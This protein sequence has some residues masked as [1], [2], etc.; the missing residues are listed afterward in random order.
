MRTARKHRAENNTSRISPN[1]RILAIASGKGGVGKSSVSAR[2]A[3]TLAQGGRKV[4]F[5]DADIWGFSIP[6]MLG[7]QGRLEA[8]RTPEGSEKPLLVPA[9]KAFRDGYIDLVSMGLLTENESDALMWR[10]LILNRAV[11]HFCEDVDWSPD[12]DMLVIDLSLIHI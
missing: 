8:G 11:Q 2:L 10:G 7:V 4:G 6:K 5:I 3:I 9:R 12:L 1:T